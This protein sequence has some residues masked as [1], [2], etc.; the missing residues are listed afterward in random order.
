METER[1]SAMESDPAAPSVLS[2]DS[3]IFNRSKRTVSQAYDR[4]LR[5]VSD[6]YGHAI[7]Y[8]RQNPG[9]TTLVAF[10]AGVG[11]GLLLLGARRHNRM[12][13]YGKPMV[14]AMSDIAMRFVRKL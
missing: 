7:A 2:Q 8:G 1:S 11:V 14:Q 10:G 13:R 4:S 6:T 5:A 3:A 9:K 12:R